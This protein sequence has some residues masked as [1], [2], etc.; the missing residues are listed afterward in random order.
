MVRQNSWYMVPNFE[1]DVLFSYV[2][3]LK[4]FCVCAPKEMA[5]VSV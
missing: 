5:Y 1:N 2:S 4:Q 3:V